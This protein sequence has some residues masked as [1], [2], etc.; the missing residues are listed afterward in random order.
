R[1]IRPAGIAIF[2]P[3]RSVFEQ[4]LTT[5]CILFLE[6]GRSASA[7][8]HSVRAASVGDVCRFLDDLLAERPATKGRT[9]YVN[10][11]GHKPEAKWLN[12]ILAPRSDQPRQLP[13]RVGDYFRCLRGIATGANDYFCLTPSE[14]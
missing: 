13:R 3:N 9:T 10:L 11:S 6:K 4:A 1:H 8:I 2:D 7:S 14:M 12:Q 5:S